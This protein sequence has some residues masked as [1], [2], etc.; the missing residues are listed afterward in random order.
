MLIQKRSHL[1]TLFPGMAKHQRGLRIVVF[2]Q[3]QQGVVALVCPD[4]IK[5]L[6]NNTGFVFRLNRNGHRIA[7]YG[8]EKLSLAMAL[9]L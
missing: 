4:P 6:F 9:N 3:G 7:L 8:D 1:A 5:E 2:E